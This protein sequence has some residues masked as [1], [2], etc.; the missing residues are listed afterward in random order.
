MRHFL[1]DD[2]LS[3]AEQAQVL[4]LA[5]ELKH[6]PYDAK[7]LAG[8][9][10][11]AMTASA[12]AQATGLPPNVVPWLPGWSSSPAAPTPM[13]APIGKPP[14][15][16]LATVTMSGRTWFRDGRCAPSSTTES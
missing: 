12:A 5:A 3:P 7:P 11:V 6:A 16:P 2:D 13:Q 9:K 14:P 8:P 15:R 4:D 10:T 1:A